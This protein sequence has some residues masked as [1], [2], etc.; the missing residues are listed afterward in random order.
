[1][2]GQPGQ[3]QPAGLRASD[4]ERDHA[5]AQLQDRFA[6]GRLS[7][8]TLMRRIDAVLRAG[9]R[10]ELAAQLADLPAQR[11]LAEAPRDWLRS[12]AR[13]A[14]AA[15]RRSLRRAPPALLL[16]PGTQRRFT[17]GREAACD[18]TLAD[19]TVSR[20]HAGLDRDG[21]GWLLADLGSTNGT[22]LNGW[23]VGG[24]VPVRP[25]DLVTFGSVTFV[26]AERP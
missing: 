7:K 26:L 2:T 24:P 12:A 8:D 25:G 16:P 9:R 1:M 13:A 14:T 21:D 3:G 23:R 18:M 17:I 20:W 15:V 10:A 4:A 22:R 19:M 5:I 6:E 11:R